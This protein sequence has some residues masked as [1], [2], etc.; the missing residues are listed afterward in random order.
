MRQWFSPP[1]WVPR[2]TRNIHMVVTGGLRSLLISTSGISSI[3][4]Y[5]YFVFIFAT[6]PPH[7]QFSVGITGR[8]E[9]K[10]KR[11]KLKAYIH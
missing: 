6:W 8:G 10:R 5:G 4:I 2:H 9:K 1:H 11:Q 7:L 3:D